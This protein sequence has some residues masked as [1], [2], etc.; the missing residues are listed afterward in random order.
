MS[1]AGSTVYMWGRKDNSKE[2]VRSGTKDVGVQIQSLHNKAA[3]G[4]KRLY[5][6]H[7]DRVL[8]IYSPNSDW[9]DLSSEGE[10]PLEQDP[11][12][13][14]VQDDAVWIVSG[15]TVWCFPLANSGS[16]TGLG[17]MKYTV[18]TDFG[19]IQDITG[20]DG[21]L[22]VTTDTLHFLY[23][24]FATDALRG[25]LLSSD[26]SA[27]IGLDRATVPRGRARFAAGRS[28]DGGSL[29]VQ[30]LLLD[31]AALFEVTADQAGVP[32]ALVAHASRKFVVPGQ[33]AVPHSVKWWSDDFIVAW[34]HGERRGATASMSVMPLNSASWWRKD[35]DSPKY[36]Q[37]KTHYLAEVPGREKF[38]LLTD[39]GATLYFAT[40]TG[41]WRFYRVP[42]TPVP[43][44]RRGRRPP[45]KKEWQY[46]GGG[47]A[48]VIVLII[49]SLVFRSRRSNEIR[50]EILDAIARERARRDDNDGQTAVLPPCLYGEDI[51]TL[52]P[53]SHMICP[54]AQ[55]IM[56]DPVTCVDGHHHFERAYL[57]RSLE[58]RAECPLSR[59]HMTESDVVDSPALNEEILEWVLRMHSEH[60][61][62]SI[63]IPEA[64]QRSVSSNPTPLQLSRAPSSE[65]FA[66]DSLPCDDPSR[67]QAY[68]VVPPHTLTADT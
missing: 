14:D 43:S 20:T 22:A 62:L 42:A 59:E 39:D 35:V 60:L 57:L 47:F 54:I 41:A 51:A 15:N 38:R 56:S 3:G 52:D 61:E 44:G 12:L 33:E 2:Y 7:S 29:F 4:H 58:I 50:R 23:I 18:S 10:W 13:I 36:L 16:F 25:N 40:T 67:Q 53:P 64:K 46:I 8:R 9:S 55:H 6:L 49:I 5:A 37:E 21:G 68:C 17:F 66:T 1:F 48:L 24:D 31:V 34:T 63:V 45:S 65:P 28:P 11:S 19:T 26:V 27:L 32:S 30:G